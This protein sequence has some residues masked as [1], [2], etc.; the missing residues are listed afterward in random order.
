MLVISMIAFYATSFDSITL[1]ASA[2][3]YR[4]IAAGKEASLP[5]K[6]FWAILL[7]LFPIV[8]LFNESSM[9]N[10]QTV[11]MIAAFPI[12]LV[13]L[14]IVFSFLKDAKKYLENTSAH[15]QK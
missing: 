9:N 10:L 5:M 13:I 2:Y 4:E 8:L 6:M 1:V 15:D 7:I 14:F 3:S 12:G 11:S